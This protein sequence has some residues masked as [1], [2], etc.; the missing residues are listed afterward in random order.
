MTNTRSLFFFPGLFSS[1]DCPSAAGSLSVPIPMRTSL[2]SLPRLANKSQVMRLKHHHVRSLLP[3]FLPVKGFY[4]KGQAPSCVHSQTA[5]SLLPGPLER[6]DREHIDAASFN[7]KVQTDV[8][9]SHKTSL[10]IHG[11]KHGGRLSVI[12]YALVLI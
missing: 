6:A 5:F 2:S 9:S 8:D 12:V 1:Q 3:L 10:R 4:I 7:L 11:E